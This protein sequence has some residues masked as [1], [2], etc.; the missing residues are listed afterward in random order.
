ME[1][2]LG[3]LGDEALFFLLSNSIILLKVNNQYWQMS[4]RSLEG[5]FE[6]MKRGPKSDVAPTVPH[7]ESYR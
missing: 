4:G 6:E 1:W 3:K 5:F 7:N 2:L